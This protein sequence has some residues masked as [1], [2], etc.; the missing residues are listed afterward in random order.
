MTR[1]MEGGR[2]ALWKSAMWK[3]EGYVIRGVSKFVCPLSHQEVDEREVFVLNNW[4]LCCR[5]AAYGNIHQI[6]LL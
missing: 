3:M 2:G 4:K 1:A 5:F 6:M